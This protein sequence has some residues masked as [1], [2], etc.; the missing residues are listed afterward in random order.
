METKADFKVEEPAKRVLSHLELSQ[1]AE[2]RSTTRIERYSF[3]EVK[4]LTQ[5]RP[6]LP[7]IVPTPPSMN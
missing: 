7:P 2:Q 6:T 3:A 1:L 5:R 4:E